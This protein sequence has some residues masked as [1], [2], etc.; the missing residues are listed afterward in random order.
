[1]LNSMESMTEAM[2]R[3]AN[4]VSMMRFELQRSREELASAEKRSSLEQLQ[5]RRTELLVWLAEARTQMTDEHPDVLSAELQ[6]A[7]LDRE[8]AKRAR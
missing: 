8:I 2:D 5:I 3:L 1:M 4:E 6:L 7:V